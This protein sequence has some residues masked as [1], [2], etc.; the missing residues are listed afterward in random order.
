MDD[1]ALLII[2]IQMGLFNRSTPIYN[3][4]Q[5]LGNINQ[6]IARAHHN[7]SPVFFIQHSNKKTL[8]KGSRNWEIHPHIKPSDKDLII[9]KRHGN[10]F[11]ET[12]LRSELESKNVMKL[13]ITGLVTHGC[14]KATCIGAKDLGYKVVLVRDGHSNYSKN[15]AKIIEEWHQRLGEVGVELMSTQEIDFQEE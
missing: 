4:Q 2:D 12:V 7:D 11:R 8:I 15:A 6:L 5:L 3:A 14:V 10:A 1:T 13:V 9:H